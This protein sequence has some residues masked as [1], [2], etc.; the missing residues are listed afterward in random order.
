[1]RA[2]GDIV[3]VDDILSALLNPVIQK[4]RENEQTFVILDFQKRSRGRPRLTISVETLAHVIE[5]VLPSR[6]IVRL[7][8]VSRATIFR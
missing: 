8:G 4:E 6:C 7:I 3:D 1:M 5:L 2:L